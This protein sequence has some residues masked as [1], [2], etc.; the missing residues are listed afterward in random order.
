M[1]KRRSRDR[2]LGR[3]SSVVVTGVG[4]TVTT[5]TGV[6]HSTLFTLRKP[7]ITSVFPRV[8]DR[9]TSHPSSSTATHG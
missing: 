5:D 4:T 6:V 9:G 3:V 1:S 7:P 2:G 8:P